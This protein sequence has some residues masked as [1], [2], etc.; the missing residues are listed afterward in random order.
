MMMKLVAPQ[1]GRSWSSSPANGSAE[2]PPDERLRR[3]MQYAAALVKNANALEYWMLRF[4]GVRRGVV[5]TRCRKMSEIQH[6]RIPR[7]FGC[8]N[9]EFSEQ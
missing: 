5:V 1:N 7:H 3:V 8:E 4:R 9:L 6:R 2:W